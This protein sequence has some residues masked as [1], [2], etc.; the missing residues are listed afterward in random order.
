MASQMVPFLLPIVITRMLQPA[1]LT[2]LI[3]GLKRR[4][5][6]LD[7][8]IKIEALLS[9][10]FTTRQLD[11][12]IDDQMRATAARA[13]IHRPVIESQAHPKG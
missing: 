11:D 6:A 4:P 7:L 9:T 2:G 10:R 13:L 5:P 3:I 8:K 12:A 1:G